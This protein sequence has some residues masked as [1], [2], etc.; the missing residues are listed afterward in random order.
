MGKARGWRGNEAGGWLSHSLCPSL[1]H[2]DTHTHTHT[3]T[4]ARTHAHTCTHTHQPN[5]LQS[6]LPLVVPGG[7]LGP[8]VPGRGGCRC[9]LV[10]CIHEVLCGPGCVGIW[11]PLTCSHAFLDVCLGF[12]RGSNGKRICLQ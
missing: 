10:V 11:K 12:P 7:T 5:S 8:F 6:C 3:H 2:P 1:S 9:L 4:Y